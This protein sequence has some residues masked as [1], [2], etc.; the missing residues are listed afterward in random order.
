MAVFPFSAR[1]LWSAEFYSTVEY[2]IARRHYFR[3]EGGYSRLG[4]NAAISTLGNLHA[5]ELLQGLLQVLLSRLTKLK[6]RQDRLT[7]FSK[8]SRWPARRYLI[9]MCTIYARVV[10]RAGFVPIKSIK[11]IG[12]PP[13]RARCKM[14]DSNKA[15]ITTARPP[16][17]SAQAGGESKYCFDGLCPS[18]PSASV[19]TRH[20]K[21]LKHVRNL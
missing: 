5:F 1:F 14:R 11:S 13:A 8:R 9:F 16:A 10:A 7:W 20:L 12:L 18:S 17:C 21:Q 19:C 4:E 2:F 6:G 15:N 3:C